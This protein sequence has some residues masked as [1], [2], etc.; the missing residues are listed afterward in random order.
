LTGTNAPAGYTYK[1][2]VLKD[3]A[4]KETF[5]QNSA[6]VNLFETAGHLFNTYLTPT[7]TVTGPGSYYLQCINPNNWKSSVREFKVAN[8]IPTLMLLTTALQSWAE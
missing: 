6:S 2:Y 8:A 3:E 4:A 5:R 1:W 7:I